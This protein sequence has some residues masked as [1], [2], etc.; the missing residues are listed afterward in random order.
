[1]LRAEQ[2]HDRAPGPVQADNAPRETKL[3]TMRRVAIVAMVGL[4]SRE[5]PPDSKSTT[6]ISVAKGVTGPAFVWEPYPA[7][8]MLLL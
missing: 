1:M 4:R 8:R 5:E 3:E 7:H 6:C 2:G